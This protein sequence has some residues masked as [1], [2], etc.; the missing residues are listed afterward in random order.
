MDS[1]IFK[2][3]DNN[4]I[5]YEKVSKQRRFVILYIIYLYANI[6]IKIADIVYSINVAGWLSY[7]YNIRIYT[8][9]KIFKDTRI[10][11]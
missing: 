1:V 6:F 3:N 11:F 8:Y 4:I 9:F 5:L 2:L 7:L 10:I